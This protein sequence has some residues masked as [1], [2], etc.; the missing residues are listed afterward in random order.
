MAFGRK[1]NLFDTMKKWFD[2][3]GWNAREAEV[4]GN[5]VLAMNFRGDSGSWLC[6][7][8]PRE[9]QQQALFYSVLESKVPAEKRAAVAEFLTRA[10]W[11]L[12]LGNFEL[13][14]NDGEVRYKTSIDIEG[15]ELKPQMLKNLVY[16]NVLTM[17][18]YMA[19]LMSIVFGSASPA[20]AIAT[21]EQK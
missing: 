20:E 18:R 21:V 7:A 10:N 2:E 13:D 1:G 6:V 17:N 15:G 19:A 8:Q 4:G 16:F 14:Y 11:G 5:P 3:D 9:E 12:I